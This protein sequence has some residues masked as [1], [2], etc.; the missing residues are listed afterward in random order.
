[1]SRYVNQAVKSLK[2]VLSNDLVASLRAVELE[3]SLAE[4]YLPD[5]V[6][7]IGCAVPNDNRFPLIEVYYTDWEM[8]NQTSGTMTVACSIAINYLAPDIDIETA[9]EVVSLYVQAI[10][11]TISDDGTLGGEVVHAIIQ[12]GSSGIQRGDKSAARLTDPIYVDVTV[13]TPK[14]KQ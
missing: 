9:Q 1:M 14:A 12:N 2:S 13:Q 4:G 5:P 11:D 7:I 10:I 3:E 6:D 8:D